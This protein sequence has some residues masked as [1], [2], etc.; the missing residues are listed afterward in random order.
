MSTG[1]LDL[2]GVDG[3]QTTEQTA[4]RRGV[5][6]WL[7]RPYG[8]DDAPAWKALLGDSHNATLFHDLDFLAYH[9]PGKHV[10]NH[11]VALWGTRIGA[12]AV[13]AVQT[14]VGA[15]FIF[16][17]VRVASARARSTIWLPPKTIKTTDRS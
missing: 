10:F 7:I 8:P 4:R 2:G 9:P 16:A 6:A 15:W 11:L 13:S 5:S 17:S 14:D 3:G 12:L 1:G